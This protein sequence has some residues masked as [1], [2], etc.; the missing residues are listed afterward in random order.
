[1]LQIFANGWLSGLAVGLLERLS[2]DGKRDRSSG[3]PAGSSA[4]LLVA[5]TGLPHQRMH[6]RVNFDM[7]WSF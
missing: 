4:S 5:L 1:M 7:R 6:R 3:S 2:G